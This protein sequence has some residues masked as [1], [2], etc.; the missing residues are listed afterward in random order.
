MLAEGEDFPPDKMSGNHTSAIYFI[1][2]F[3]FISK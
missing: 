1:G 2:N 3:I